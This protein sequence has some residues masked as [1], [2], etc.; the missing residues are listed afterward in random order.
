MKFSRVFAVTG[1]VL[2]GACSS[3]KTAP[4]EP[5]VQSESAQSEQ[6]VVAGGQ[7]ASPSEQSGVDARIANGEK[8]YERSCAGCHD[9]GTGGAPKPG[10]TKDWTVRISQGIELLT[11][12]SIEGYE[13]KKGAM[14]P[15]GGNTELTDEEVSSAVHYMVAR[16]K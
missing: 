12:K 16:S 15:R 13:G 2:L 10:D 1:M 7:P 3:Q 14:P 9:S 8:V 6:G 5:G 11:K 4:P